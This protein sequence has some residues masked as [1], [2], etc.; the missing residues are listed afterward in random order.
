M[1]LGKKIRQLRIKAGLTQEQLGEKLGIA[2]IYE[3]MGDDENAAKT[4]G[5]IVDLLEK[6]WGLTEETDSAITAAKQD[7]ARLLAKI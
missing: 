5:R 1:E 7:R 3:I 6:E 2:D 4:Y